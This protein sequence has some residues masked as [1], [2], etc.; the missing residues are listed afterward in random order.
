MGLA[1]NGTAC[2]HATIWK[3]CHAQRSQADIGKLGAHINMHLTHK[4]NSIVA[5]SLLGLAL[6]GSFRKSFTTSLSTPVCAGTACS[7]GNI[8]GANGAVQKRG[9]RNVISSV[10]AFCM[11][12]CSCHKRVLPSVEP[13]Q[14]L[15]T[16]SEHS[17]RL[18][19]ATFA[20]TSR[21]SKSVA[22]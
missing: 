10:H 17:C 15:R 7:K 11:S 6:T 4:C 19:G 3:A 8:D 9:H 1:G 20:W 2:W 5:A 16:A 21:P 18:A 22:Q 12:Y 14:C 13:R